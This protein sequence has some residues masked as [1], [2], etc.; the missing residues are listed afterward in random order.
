MTCR[1]NS[2]A[3]TTGNGH[4][5]GKALKPN[6]DGVEQNHVAQQESSQD[7]TG[8][9]RAG[10]D[11]M[12]GIAAKV[13]GICLH[14]D[15]ADALRDEPV[16]DAGEGDEGNCVA[17]GKGEHV[18]ASL[19]AFRVCGYAEAF[20]LHGVLAPFAGQRHRGE[21]AVK[22]GVQDGNRRVRRVGL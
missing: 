8:P 13:C 16:E 22:P 11:I 6:A 17:I 9:V 15:Q 12:R 1:P 10:N 2:Q 7:S 14:N 20:A 4:S 19:R 5:V 3:T 18:A 21:Q